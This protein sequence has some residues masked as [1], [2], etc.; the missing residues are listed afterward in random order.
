MFIFS[1]PLSFHITAKTQQPTG[2]PVMLLQGSARFAVSAFNP[3][4]GS[5]YNVQIQFALKQTRFWRMA[6]QKFDQCVGRQFC[7]ISS[8]SSERMV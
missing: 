7:R 6:A 4:L 2:L 3:A 8:S 5:S 1:V